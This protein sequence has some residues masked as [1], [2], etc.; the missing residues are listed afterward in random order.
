M[1]HF[2]S[3]GAF[4][5]SYLRYVFLTATTLCGL[6]NAQALYA[7]SIP[8][9]ESKKEE[10]RKL[11]EEAEKAQ[12]AWEDQLKKSREQAE[13]AAS[14]S[15]V[16]EVKLTGTAGAN[17]QTLAVDP[18]G[19]VLALVAQPRGFSAAKQGVSSTVF[20]L[21]R[22][23]KETD[24]LTVDFHASAVNAAPDGT[25]YVA[26]S[27]KVARFDKKGK[28]LGDVVELPFIAE[29]LKNPEKMKE[30]AE[31]QVKSQKES[32]EKM[33]KQYK[34]RL[35]K[36]EESEKKAKEK[37]EELSKS[38]TTQLKQAKQI[39]ESFKQSEKYYE[40]IS[41]DSI[42]QSMIG[43]LKI[44]NSI[45]ANDKE[46]YV[47][48][49]EMQGYGYSLW[50]MDLDLKN[51]KKVMSNLSGC[52]G[53]MDVQCCDK[54]IV[55]AENT[56]HRFARY[57]REGKE[58]AAG[59]KRGQDSDPSG[60]GGCCNPMNVKECGGG[61]ILT[62]ESEGIIKRFGPTGEFK[63]VV[64]AVPISGGCKNVAIGANADVSRVYF[65]DQPGS[66]VLILA[67]KEAK[68]DTK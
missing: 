38:E 22:D 11:Q 41:V 37:G 33:V 17:L 56:K 39:M 18:E 64:G 35:A 36:L 51:P 8:K 48:C 61:D 59:G 40:S 1:D 20:I 4:M 28:S 13:K 21:D 5:T 27:G 63:G 26:G 23:G 32:F 57:D 19:R 67:K 60:F 53:Q 49:G 7:Q 6:A 9:E 2:T 43:R 46:L 47:V 65:C 42:L 12:K 44:V 54:D 25:I 30:S 45:S 55:I 10:A 58:L 16:K 3:P 31:K 34:D 15:L 66:R 14:H 52:C 68:S 29:N 62:A 24:K 50:R